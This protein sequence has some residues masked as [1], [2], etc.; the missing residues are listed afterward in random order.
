MEI[1]VFKTDIHNRQQAEKLIPYIETLAGI[2]KCNVDLHDRDKVLRIESE[3]VS[4]R[5]IEQHLHQ[6]GY[7]CKELED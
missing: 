2:R 3:A 7:Y 1:L 4:P 5:I 6:A